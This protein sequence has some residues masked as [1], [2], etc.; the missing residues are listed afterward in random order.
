MLAQLS[1]VFSSMTKDGML[2]IFGSEG[3]IFD[4]FRAFSFAFAFCFE[5]FSLVASG[6]SLR[7]IKICNFSSTPYGTGPFK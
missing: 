2:L 1:F 3:E 4:D 6:L 5:S 7:L